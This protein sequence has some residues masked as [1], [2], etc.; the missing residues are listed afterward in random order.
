MKL[1][2]IVAI[3]ILLSS[4]AV[5]VFCVPQLTSQAAS[6][7]RMEAGRWELQD[8]I[9]STGEVLLDPQLI[10]AVG[11]TLVVFDYGDFT[12]EALDRRGR[13]LWA[14]GRRG[15]GPGEFG[16]PTSLAIGP[17]GAIWI[18]DPV[19]GR[20]SRFSR[21]G[22]F[23]D[24]VT[25]PEQLTRVL[26]LGHYK[27][28]ALGNFEQ[29]RL[30]QIYDSMGRVVRGIPLPDSLRDVPLINREAFLSGNDQAINV[31]FRFSDVSYVIN[32]ATGTIAGFHG[33]E[34]VRFATP[35]AV[36]TEINGKPARI[37]RANPH[38]VKATL[39][40]TGGTARTLT[41]LFGGT[42]ADSGRVVDDYDRAG[43][44]Y[45]GS[46]K[47]PERPIALTNLNG[48]LAGIVS[49]PVP[50]IY[51]WRWVPAAAGSPR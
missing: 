5:A 37:T 48:D 21:T 18:N 25:V 19:N 26:P 35:L 31:F 10:A 4:V 23:I 2:R 40:V 29:N 36:S 33:P 42:T 24:Q 47:L 27:F 8:R 16:N 45:L 20:I 50:S 28:A 34:Q 41:V 14:V 7:R 44:R 13:V 38:A 3:R 32:P 6:G 49:D 17:E 9:D 51:V 39:S 46:R 12:L 11:D 30:M 22:R 15:G 43:G 1:L